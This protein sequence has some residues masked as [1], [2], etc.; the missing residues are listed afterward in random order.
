MREL[1]P[2]AL[3]LGPGGLAGPGRRLANRLA[4]TGQGLADGP[5][6]GFADGPGRGVALPPLCHGY[7]P[8]R[9]GRPPGAVPS[10]RAMASLRLPLCS[11]VKM[12]LMWFLTVFSLMKQVAAIC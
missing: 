9:P 2:A 11:F 4:G 10:H 1:G 12:R 3:L 5:V 6:D 8:P 7:L